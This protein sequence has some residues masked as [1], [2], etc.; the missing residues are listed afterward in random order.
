MGRDL[1]LCARHRFDLD[2]ALELL[3]W[4]TDL[5]PIHR[6]DDE[7]AFLLTRNQT[8]RCYERGGRPGH[9]RVLAH[10]AAAGSPWSLASCSRTP[11]R[12]TRLLPGAGPHDSLVA[13]C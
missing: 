11:N 7:H 1:A 2:D 5:G 10:P 4:D 9:E 6:L 3:Q 12:R 13:E 8:S